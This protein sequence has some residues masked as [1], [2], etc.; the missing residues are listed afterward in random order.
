MLIIYPPTVHWDYMIARPQQLMLAF[1]HQGDNVIFCEP[2]SHTEQKII[3]K[4][5]GLWLDYGASTQQWPDSFQGVKKILWV[6]YPGNVS[7]IG[8]YQEDMV[9]Y[10]VLDYPDDDFAAWKPYVQELLEKCHIVL[11]VSRPLFNDFIKR[12]PNV[13]LVRNG[14]DYDFFA[15]AITNEMPEDIKKISKPIVGFYGALAPWIDWMLIE[16]LAARNPNVSFVFIGPTIA[17]KTENL[18]QQHNIYFLGHKPYGELPRYAVNFDI[19]ILPFKKTR[20]TSYVNPVKIYEYL[21]M[22]KP[23]VA[24]DLPEIMEMLPYVNAAGSRNEFQRELSKCLQQEDNNLIEARKG[25]ALKNTWAERVRQI[26]TIIEK[27]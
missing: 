6:S 10:D 26:K 18:P 7:Q 5:E 23:V 8:K 4:N 19:C 17:M 9:V 2:G 22:G 13:H 11:T 14:V 3:R 1:S 24:T 25:F 21:A 12:H 20:L 27:N 15:N 16:E